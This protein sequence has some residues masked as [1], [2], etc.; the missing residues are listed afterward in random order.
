MGPI[1][2]SDSE[3]YPSMSSSK[4]LSDSQFTTMSVPS[5]GDGHSDRPERAGGKDPATNLVVDAFFG[6]KVSYI[7]I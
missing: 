7:I 3:E 2:V 4:F 1:N 5:I 6:V